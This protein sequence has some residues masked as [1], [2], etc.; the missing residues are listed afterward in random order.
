M[1]LTLISATTALPISLLELQEQLRVDST[2][3]NS[4]LK[5]QLK[6]AVGYCER[7]IGGHRRIMRHT[8]DASLSAFPSSGRIDLP[9]P[10]L[11]S[12]T[13]I[14]YYDTDNEQQ[15]LSS[16][17]YHTITPTEGQGRIERKSGES[18]PTTKTRPDAVTVR[19][20]AGYSTGST[21]IP[22]TL[23]HAIRLVASHYNENREGSITGT[24]SRQVE[25]GVESLLAMNEYGGYA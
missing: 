17:A 16:T 20:D 24:V 13:S 5:R 7:A 19:F 9:L 18:W 21:G 2:A 8:Y 15:T 10:P 6:A 14:Q 1:D 23:R 3:D 4:D 11:R 22:E 12:V 25:F